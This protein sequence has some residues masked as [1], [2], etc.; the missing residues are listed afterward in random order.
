MINN[1]KIYIDK[2]LK[3]IKIILIKEIINNLSNYL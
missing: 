2:K 3:K 1:K